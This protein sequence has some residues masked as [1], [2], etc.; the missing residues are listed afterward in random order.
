M[1]LLGLWRGT[2]DDED[3]LITENNE[4]DDPGTNCG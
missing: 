4:G 3:D 2:F 1:A